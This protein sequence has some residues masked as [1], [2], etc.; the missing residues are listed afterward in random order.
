MVMSDTLHY[1]IEAHS[2]IPNLPPL[3]DREADH[4]LG[5]HI[6]NFQPQ[7]TNDFDRIE[8]GSL[9]CLQLGNILAN[10]RQPI[11]WDSGVQMVN[12]VIPNIGR[13]PAHNQIGL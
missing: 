13:K 3:P 9:G 8:R 10:F 4:P 1:G 12:M 2:L 6:P 5:F 11:E 7:T